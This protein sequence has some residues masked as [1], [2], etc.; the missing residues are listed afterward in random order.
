MRSF[1]VSL[2]DWGWGNI[3]P[4]GELDVTASW[5]SFCVGC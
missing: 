2:T 1:P 5:V 4:T 3:A